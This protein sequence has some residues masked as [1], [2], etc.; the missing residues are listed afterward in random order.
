MNS[1]TV[2]NLFTYNIQTRFPGETTLTSS[3]VNE[4]TGTDEAYFSKCAAIVADVINIYVSPSLAIAGLFG[5][6]LVL[7]ALNSN[8]SDF[9]PSIYLMKCL[10]ATDAVVCLITTVFIF[11]PK[12]VIPWEVNLALFEVYY[13]CTN[14]SINTTFAIVFIRFLAVTLPLRVPTLISRYRVLLFYSLIMIWCLALATVDSMF[15]LNYNPYEISP[16][17]FYALQVTLIGIGQ[18]IPVLA[19]IFLNSFLLYVLCRQGVN[20]TSR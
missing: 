15:M 11:M 12:N 4:P 10:A 13:F 19:L 5:N 20:A 18:V 1:T 8:Q 9:N 2:G 7:F 6:V 3:D 17:N 14:N 16:T